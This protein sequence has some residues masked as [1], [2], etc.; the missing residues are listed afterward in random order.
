MRKAPS[1]LEDTYMKFARTVSFVFLFVF[2]SAPIFAVDYKVDTAFNLQS[3]GSVSVVQDIFVQ[4]DGKL[5]VGGYYCS[6]NVCSPYLKRH[7]SNGSIDTTFN[8][9]ISPVTPMS[10][11]Q[12]IRQLPNG[13][14]LITGLFNIGTV[15]SSYA[16]LNADGSLDATLAPANLGADFGA[17][18][19]EPTP[20]GKFVACTERTIN[21]QLYKIAHRINADGT[22]DPTFRVTFMDGFCGSLKVLPSGKLLITVS[23]QTGQT[24]VKPVHRLNADGSKDMSFDADVPVGSYGDALTEMPSGKLLVT[25]SVSGQ[26]SEHVRRLMPDGSLDTTFPLCAAS[27]FLPQTNGDV[28]M[29]GCKRWTGYFGN[30]LS[31]SRVFPDGSVDQ[32]VDAIYF[33]TGPRGAREAGNNKYYIFGGFNSVNSNSGWAKLI[34]LEPNLTPT[35]AKFDFDNDGKSDLAVFRPSDRTWYVK[36]STAGFS[37]MQWGLSTDALAAGHYDNDG[38]TDIAIF[39]DGILHAYSPAFGHRQLFIG[40]TGDKPLLGNYEDSGTDIEDFAVRGVRSGAVNWFIREGGS[41]ANPVGGVSTLTLSGELATDKPVVGDFNGD[42]RDEFG[43]F[44]DGIWYTVDRYNYAPPATFQ[45]G[46]AGDIPVP[47]DYDGDR[48]TDYAIFRPS[49]GDWWIRRSTAGIFVIRFGQNGDIPV[50]ADYDGDGKTDVAIYR[51]GTWWQYRI[52]TGTIQVEQW[53]IAG[54]KPVPAQNQ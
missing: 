53:G 6:L 14:F 49:T 45:W 8:A 28:L 7:N 10:F 36:Q 30:R 2:C 3:P 24:A 5:L 50:P 54:D 48:Q 51:N 11:V 13:Q 22:P 15:R 20:D 12:T 23:T 41:V 39:R 43:Y 4:A 35:K 29:N 19:I 32:T 34:R 44:R 40:A 27:F 17:M 52:G 26:N 33:D 9:A 42:S 21:S 37:Y 16:K 46:A 1:N 31:F 25:S 38:K 18:I 47:G